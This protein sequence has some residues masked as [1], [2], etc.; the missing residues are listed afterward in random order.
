MMRKLTSEDIERGAAHPS[1]GRALSDMS[2]WR[3]GG[4]LSR[5]IRRSCTGGMWTI[6]RDGKL[7][8]EPLYSELRNPD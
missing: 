2:T 7:G 6:S 5:L 3:F 1:P 4:W 8:C